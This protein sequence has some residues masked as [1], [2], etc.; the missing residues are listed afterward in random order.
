V[1]PRR[2][3][4]RNAFRAVTAAALGVFSAGL[5][6]VAGPVPA[7]HAATST[8]VSSLVAGRQIQ[9]DGVPFNPLPVQYR[10]DRALRYNGLTL[11]QTAAFYADAKRLGFNT[12]AIPLL[13]NKFETSEGVYDY[14]WLNSFI[15][16]AKANGLKL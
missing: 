7:A 2:L 10:V 13:W 11:A 12:I 8:V 15:D 6:T 16:N 4:A 1:K 5:L 9:V 14:T 3:R